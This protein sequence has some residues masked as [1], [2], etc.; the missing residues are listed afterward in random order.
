MKPKM[1]NGQTISICT[2][3]NVQFSVYTASCYVAWQPKIK[4]NLKA[5]NLVLLSEIIMLFFYEINYVLNICVYFAVVGL[6]KP[7]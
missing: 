6:Q 1:V 4:W 5:N 7:F 2:L 3:V